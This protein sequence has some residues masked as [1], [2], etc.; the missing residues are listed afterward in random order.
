MYIKYT[1]TKLE[2]KAT[3]IGEIIK[4]DLQDFNGIVTDNVSIFPSFPNFAGLT[5]GSEVIGAISIKQNGQY[6]NKVLNEERT[7]TIKDGTR[8][9]GIKAA[10]ER[11]EVMIEKAQERKNDSIAYFNSI[12][13][14]INAVGKYDPT[15][16]INDYQDAIVQFRD[17]FLA[18]W[19]KYDAS[20][21]TDKKTPF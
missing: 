8:G 12:N 3:K 11:K 2:K 4:A 16:E 19:R 6:T 10:Q 20:D 1:I 5:V 7:S 18:E 13:C 14:A 17:W 15:K 9:S 21:I